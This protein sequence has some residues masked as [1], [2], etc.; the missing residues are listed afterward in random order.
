MLRLVSNYAFYGLVE[1][2]SSQI[3]H[4]PDMLVEEYVINYKASFSR[5]RIVSYD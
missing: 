3:L 1:A 5:I 2:F 4:K